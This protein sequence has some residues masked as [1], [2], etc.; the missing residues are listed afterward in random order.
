MVG[1]GAYAIGMLLG[2][3]GQWRRHGDFDTRPG[4]RM[5]WLYTLLVATGLATAMLPLPA[6]RPLPA[7][8][9]WVG[10]AM[11]LLATALNA[12]IARHARPGVAAP[13]APGLSARIPDPAL[14]SALLAFYGMLL[15]AGNPRVLP[16]AACIGAAFFWW[17]RRRGGTR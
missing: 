14:A 16:A 3:R 13:A 11:L 15:A 1:A 2:M 5:Q 12:S 10:C 6:A 17:V 8:A 4:A 9:L 7:W